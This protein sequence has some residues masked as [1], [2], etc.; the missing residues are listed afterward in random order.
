MVKQCP[1]GPDYDGFDCNPEDCDSCVANAAHE[2]G[3]R[4]FD[5]MPDA[6]YYGG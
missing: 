3:A 6:D 2:T 1:L 5:E 4:L